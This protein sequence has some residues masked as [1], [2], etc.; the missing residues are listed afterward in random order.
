MILG[1]DV[2]DNFI[3]RKTI[4]ENADVIFRGYE[5]IAGDLGSLGANIR[6]LS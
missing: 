1:F 4:I 6:T 2:F 3:Y 5:D